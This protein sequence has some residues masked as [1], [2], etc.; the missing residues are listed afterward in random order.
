[1]N[2]PASFI[3]FDSL[4][5]ITSITTEIDTASNRIDHYDLNPRKKEL[6]EI[7]KIRQTETGYIKIED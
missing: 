2:N 5:D 6:K 7:L 1:M 4:K 3:L